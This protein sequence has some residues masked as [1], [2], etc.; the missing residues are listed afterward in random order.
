MHSRE[1]RN[2]HCHA[3]SHH[4]ESHTDINQ[5]KIAI[6]DLDNLK[7]NRSITIYHI[8]RGLGRTTRQRIA[9]LPIDFLLD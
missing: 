8:P 5:I 2:C 6:P 3:M 9:I 4:T 7:P 1:G